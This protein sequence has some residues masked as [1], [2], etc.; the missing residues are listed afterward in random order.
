M[1][2]VNAA[3]VSGM[4]GQPGGV[5]HP[6]LMGQ[7]TFHEFVTVEEEKALL[8]MLDTGPPDW[9]DSNFNG[10]HRCAI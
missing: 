9:V 10:L 5:A 3:V 7:W 1:P 2:A 8:R 6:T 4:G